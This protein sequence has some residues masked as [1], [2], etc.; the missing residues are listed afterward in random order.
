MPEH[1]SSAEEIQQMLRTLR[2]GLL[3]LRAQSSVGPPRLCIIA[4]SEQDGFTP[5]EV[6]AGL[7]DAVQA[8][9]GEVYGATQVYHVDSFEKFY[10]TDFIRSV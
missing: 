3:K 9:L 2:E 6:A 4:R 10:D 1:I 8:L 5:G 7:E